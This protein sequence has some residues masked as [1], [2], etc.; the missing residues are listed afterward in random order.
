MREIRTEGLIVLQDDL[1]IEYKISKIE[2]IEREDESYY[3]VFT[4]FYNVIDLLSS[5]L[6]QGIPGI[7]LDLRKEKYIRENRIP[8]FISERTPGKKREDLWDL[9][10]Q[11]GMN[12]LNQL[13]WLIRTETR[14]SGDRLYV[15]RYLQ[16]EV[17]IYI[18]PDIP[19]TGSRARNICKDI[20]DGICSGA[21]VIA[22]GF[23]ITDEN[24]KDFYHLLHVLYR[25][26]QEY[27]KHR[28]KE[29][30]KKSSAA[31]NYKGRQR[32]QIDDTKAF[33]IFKE[34]RS[35]SLTEAEAVEKF[36][37]SRSTFFR[38]LKEYEN[39]DKIEK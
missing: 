23:H 17:P 35:G 6:F 26:E 8:V 2:Y 10:E 38:R 21:D 15:K 3:Y 1:G 9:L 34:Y 12:Y 7:D 5:E 32:I 24:R 11:A 30:I 31:G 4:P 27:P 36:G 18:F 37:T 19:K 14:Y 29:G 28:R 13:E 39:S 20:L 25:N 16:E 22:E 33:E